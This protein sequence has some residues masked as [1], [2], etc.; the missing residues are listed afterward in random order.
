MSVT[1][2]CIIFIRRQLLKTCPSLTHG[3]NKTGRGTCNSWGE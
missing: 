1:I 3:T 2:E